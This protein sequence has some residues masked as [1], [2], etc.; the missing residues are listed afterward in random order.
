VSIVT[1]VYNEAKHLEECI[2]SVLAQ[3][4]Q[5]WDYTIVNNC[6]TDGSADVARM[7]VARD[8]RIRI[9]ENPRFLRVVASHNAAF[10]QIS[11]E[12]KYCKM[13]FGDDW[14]YPQ[15]LEEMVAI[16]EQ[17]PSVG[18]VGAY[19]LQEDEVMW[20]GLPYSS[21]VVSGREVCRRL[22]LD[23][24]YV[25]G[26]ATS[27]LF[28]ADLVRSMDPLYNEGNLHADK[29]ACIA[30]LK[31]CDF[32]FVH[33]ILTF[34]RLRP[35]SLGAVTEDIHTLL[36]G[37]LQSLVAHGRD[38]LDEA[39]F[40]RCLHRLVKEYYNFLAVT[41]MRGRRDKKFWEYHRRKLTEAGIGFSQARLARATLIRLGKALLNPNETA[42]KLLKWWRGATSPHRSEGTTDARNTHKVEPATMA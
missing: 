22:F 17:N 30:L 10:R 21:R 28:R 39:E 40:Q 8:P 4:Y 18:I 14:I 34:K 26:T 19:G 9:V 3:T 15:C 20:A 29:E 35:G 6:S 24:T 1:P 31:S 32:G 41:L 38:F 16:A 25:F 7:Y 5:N 36:A 42:D 37:H 2:E 27:I 23:E 13:I 12:C 11:P 33:Q